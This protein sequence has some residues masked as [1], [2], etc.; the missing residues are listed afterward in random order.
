MVS[1]DAL[2]ESPAASLACPAGSIA[3]PL[4]T[5]FDEMPAWA[6]FEHDPGMTTE[7]RDSAMRVVLADQLAAYAQ[8]K[9]FETHFDARERILR[10]HALALP[11]HEVGTEAL[12]A[13]YRDDTRKLVVGTQGGELIARI[14]DPSLELGYRDGREPFAASGDTWWQIR[15]DATTVTVEVAP[16]GE[17]WRT[18]LSLPAFTWLEDVRPKFGIGTRTLLPEAGEARFDLLID[19]LQVR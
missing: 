10:T 1:P 6:Y 16:D 3:G 12:L 14:H 2:L 17:T 7:L 19:C 18:L 4:T 13:W 15:I 5:T 11:T 8:F 9:P